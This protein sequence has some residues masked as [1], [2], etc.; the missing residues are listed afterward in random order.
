[1]CEPL[2]GRAT[3]A[4][5]AAKEARPP[6][7]FRALMILLGAESDGWCLPCHQT[8]ESWLRRSPLSISFV[9][10][11]MVSSEARAKLWVFQRIDAPSAG[12]EAVSMGSAAA[13]ASFC[14]DARASVRAAS[15]S[16][17]IWRF[18]A[19][20]AAASSRAAR[21]RARAISRA[22]TATSLNSRVRARKGSRS[23]A[24][25]S[26]DSRVFIWEDILCVLDCWESVPLLG[27]ETL[28]NLLEN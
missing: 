18:W 24:V 20:S 10:W 7:L 16:V 9:I 4:C 13:T 21:A 1:M 11:R 8:E 25:E 28:S 27:R 19:S 23:R 12:A 14:A 15:V 26:R 5:R 2:V 6:A 22:A 3:S 17:I